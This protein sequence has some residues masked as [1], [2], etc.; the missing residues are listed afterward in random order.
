MIKPLDITYDSNTG[1]Y[2]IEGVQVTK[3]FVESWVH[4]N[5]RWFKCERRENRVTIKQV[6]PEVE[7]SF[8]LAIQLHDAR[9]KV[10]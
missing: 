9:K 5:N 6:A 1:V 4:P 3:E 2:T 8:E 10:Q 7:A